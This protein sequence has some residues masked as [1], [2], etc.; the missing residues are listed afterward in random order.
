MAS[1]GAT[2]F[3]PIIFKPFPMRLY[4][5][6]LFYLSILIFASF[7]ACE[8]RDKSGK[9]VDTPTTGSIQIMVDECYKPVIAS[10]IDVFD[11]IYLRASIAATYTS[12]GEAFAALVR[13]SIQV[14][15][16][17]R[18]LTETELS[19]HFKP[20]GFTPSMTPIAFDAVAFIV[21][22]ENKD[23]VFT[24]DQLRSILT[25]ET[26]KW[27]ALNPQSKLSDILLVFDNPLSGTVRYARDTIAG[28][29]PLPSNATALQTNQEVIAYVA[30]NKNAIGIIGANWISDTDDKGVQAFRREIKI[31]DIAKTAGAIGYG[32]YQAYLAT[33]QYPF[34]RTIYLINA[35]ARKGLGLGLASFLASDPGQRMMLKDGLLPAQA[36]TRLIEVTRK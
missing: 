4:R 2:A 20:R 29:S 23:T 19:K 14:I 12:E 9:L 27:T 16:A 35:Q 33:G 36:P 10:A 11:S 30:K 22:P 21:H 1:T 31:A 3:M 17:A 28:G 26:A 6:H 24:I 25:G 13:D 15:I 8:N 32:P 18:E 7:T 5:K 34:R